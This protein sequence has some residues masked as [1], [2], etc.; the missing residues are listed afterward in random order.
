MAI[1]D[2]EGH[3]SFR[4]PFEI[5]IKC[6]AEWFKKSIF[7]IYCDDEPSIV[8]LT[9][10]QPCCC[11]GSNGGRA[12]TNTSFFQH[13][14]QCDASR[15]TTAECL[16]HI[17]TPL[18]IISISSIESHTSVAAL[19]HPKTIIPFDYPKID[20]MTKSAFQRCPHLPSWV[21]KRF[22]HF[23]SIYMKGMYKMKQCFYKWY[24]IWYIQMCSHTIDT[25]NVSQA[26]Y[27]M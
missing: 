27:W 25:C 16:D 11:S 22:W 23:Q 17:S 20:W 6:Y 15:N 5:I 24:I 12:I 8:D 19:S 1:I 9:S 4:F 2:D 3:G 26:W 13:T 7:L 18:Y 14:L 10:K 21:R